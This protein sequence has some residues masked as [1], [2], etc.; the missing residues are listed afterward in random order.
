MRPTRIYCMHQRTR[1]GRSCIAAS[2]IVFFISVHRPLVRAALACRTFLRAVRSSSGFRRC[3]RALHPPQIL[4]LYEDPWKPCIPAFVPLRSLSDQ[5]LTAAVRGADFLLTRIPEDSGDPGWEMHDC[6]CGYV[7]LHHKGTKQIAA[8]NPLTQPLDI[9]PRPPQEANCDSRYLNFRII[10]SGE[11]QRSFHVVCVRRRKWRRRI[12]VRISVFSPDIRVWQG[13]SWVEFSTTQ[14]QPAGEDGGDNNNAYI[15]IATLVNAYDRLSRCYIKNQPY[16]LNT[17]MPHLCRI[18]LPRPLKDMD[19]RHV[20]LGW[21]KDGKP[22]LACIDDFHA[23][24]GTLALW[25]WRADDGDG[26]DKWM[27]HKVFPLNTFIDVTMCSKEYI[28]NVDFVAV[29]DGFAFLSIDYAIYSECLISFCP[30]T[31]NVNKLFS[32]TL[33]CNIHPY[34]MAWPPSLVGNKEDLETKV[35]GD[36]L[37]DDGPVVTEETPSVLVTALRSY[38][39]ALINGNGAKVAEIEAFLLFI[40]GEKKSLVAE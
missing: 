7:V 34:I 37:V 39:E 11:D 35:T 24:K 12:R 15:N 10:F 40:E 2:G 18:D 26:V 19:P 25:M 27:P 33:D 13:F 20:E 4:G 32:H 38:K 9:F 30:E 8:Y 31:E 17:S 21:T 1:R 23:N 29:I 14:A 5:D 6:R 28:V 22:C 16:M 3:F 36:N